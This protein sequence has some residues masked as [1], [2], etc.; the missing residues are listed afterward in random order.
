MKNIYYY[1]FLT[2]IIISCQKDKEKND[3]TPIFD[4]PKIATVTPNLVNILKNHT[5]TIKLKTPNINRDDVCVAF[6]DNDVVSVGYPSFKDSITMMVDLPDHYYQGYTY[7]GRK[8]KI[9]LIKNPHT[10]NL[11]TVIEY[12]DS[13]PDSIKIALFHDH[14]KDTLY[15]YVSP[16]EYLHSL[17]YI[18]Y[19][20]ISTERIK[21]FK[22]NVFL[23][24]NDIS[25]NVDFSFTFYGSGTYSFEANALQQYVTTPI[26]LPDGWYDLTIK[27]P[28]GDEI[29][30]RS[31]SRVY[32]KSK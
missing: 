26:S 7:V 2:T 18:P 8:F 16:D 29:F 30:P 21:S 20:N 17:S 6:N 9:D 13:Y 22:Y 23:G 4:T 19:S 11:E 1:L 14:K 5:L 15:N 12:I 32:L 31:K 28:E 27:D 25:Q 24:Q 10:I 3:P